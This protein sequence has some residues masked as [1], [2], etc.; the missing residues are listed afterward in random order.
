MSKKVDIVVSFDT[1]GSMYP[2]ISEVRENVSEFVRDLFKSIPDLRIGIIAHGDYCDADDPYC[3]RIMDLTEDVD[4]LCEFVNTTKRTCGGDS[5]ECYELVLNQART[6][7]NWRSGSAK[8]LVMIGDASPH[9]VDYPMNKG[10]LDWEVETEKL[11]EQDIKVY[12]VHALANY[13]RS[14]EK[15]YATVARITNGVYLTLDNFG[16]V[17]KL[18]KATM[19]AEYDEEK[20]SE[21][22]SI[23]RKGARVSMSLSRNINRLQGLPD[24]SPGEKV[25]YISKDGLVAV[26]AGRFQVMTVPEN[27]VIRDF[28][29]SRGIEFKP[30]RGFYELTKSEK[31][32]QHKEII[33]EDRKTG[34]L[35]TGAQVREFLG[36]KPQTVKGGVTERLSSRDKLDGYRIFVQ[37]TS[38]NRKLIGGTTFMYEISD[39]EEGESI[40]DVKVTAEHKLGSSCDTKTCG[41]EGKRDTVSKGKAKKSAGK[42][43]SKSDCKAGTSTDEKVLNSTPDSGA[44]KKRVDKEEGVKAPKRGTKRVHKDE[45]DSESSVH[46]EVLKAEFIKLP[47][48]T[49]STDTEGVPEVLNLEALNHLGALIESGTTHDVSKKSHKI[50]VELTDS[51][52]KLLESLLSI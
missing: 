9:G 47:T 10:K 14:S 50:N 7:L 45:G 18:I 8:A 19:L 44:S 6:A 41:A 31:V 29:T 43:A 5:D 46:T 21:F 40:G 3:I 36:L 34:E 52:Y 11:K 39:F 24:V 38:Y 49:S 20:L 33:L 22:V 1:T 17:S 28:I 13:R 12:A 23:I 15:F 16:D 2:V 30:G 32:Q 42:K 37:S 25:E 48:L 35:F 51:E 4:E 27:C 26:P